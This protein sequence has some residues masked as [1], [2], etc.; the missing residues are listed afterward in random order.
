MSSFSEKSI[1]FRRLPNKSFIYCKI[2][3]TLAVPGIVRSRDPQQFAFRFS[4]TSRPKRRLLDIFNIVSEKRPPC[5]LQTKKLTSQE[6]A[7]PPTRTFSV[8]PGAPS[9]FAAHKLMPSALQ[10]DQ[11]TSQERRFMLFKCA[12]LKHG[13]PPVI[14]RAL[15]HGR[16]PHP[17]DGFIADKRFPR[18]DR[19]LFSACAPT[20]EP[21]TPFSRAP[22]SR[23]RF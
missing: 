21:R 7:R 16:S 5:A 17:R 11:S 19:A 14:L 23:C 3:Q 12:T 6:V 22:A 9:P 15:S 2:S 20:A 1:S 13:R 10:Q 4:V 8:T 18:A